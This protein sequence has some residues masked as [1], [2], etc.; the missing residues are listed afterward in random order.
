MF[1]KCPAA[2][3]LASAAATPF[4][5]FATTTVNTAAMEALFLKRAL[6]DPSLRRPHRVHCACA[7][8]GLALFALDEVRPHLPCVHAAW[9]VLS[10]VA[11]RETLP[12]VQRCERAGG[13][14]ALW[15]AGAAVGVVGPGRA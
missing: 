11:V 12:L 15:D 9:H 1:P 6:A 13:G 10:S 3:T 14:G 2:V 5:P 8:V 7:G 4:A